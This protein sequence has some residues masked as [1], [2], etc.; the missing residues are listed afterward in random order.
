[1]DGATSAAAVAGQM[2]QGGPGPPPSQATSSHGGPRR[3]RNVLSNWGTYLVAIGV[4]FFLSPFII[5][6]L[7]DTAYGIWVLLGSLVG[8]LGLLDLGVRGAVTRYIAKFHARAQHGEA[9]RVASSALVL[10]TA[11]GM[12]AIAF[13]LGL[14]VLVTQFFEI[15][16]PLVVPARI[17]VI[18]GGV[19]VAVSLASGVFGGV[20]TGM[21]RIDCINGI[22]VATQGFRVLAIVLALKWGFG[23]VALATIQLGTS[24]LSGL[25]SY[26]LSRLLYPELRLLLREYDRKH[27]DMVLSF[28]V[29]AFLLQASGMLILFTDSIV[30]GAF[31]PVSFITF[32]AIAASLTEY[33][34]APISAIT[35]TLTP[36]ASALEAVE[37]GHQVQHLVLTAGRL[38]TLLALPILVTFVVR[39]ESFIGLW[40]GPAYAEPAGKVLWILSL[41]LGFAVAYQVVVVT[42][43]GISKHAGLVPAFLVEAAANVG[44]SILWVNVYG[45]VGV[46]WGTA[47]PRLA[48]CL[49][50][51][52]WYVR[53][54]LRVPIRRFYVETW[55]RP[56]AAIVPFALGSYAIE[57]WWPA[58]NLFEYFAQVGLA[59]PLAALGG[60]M[61]CLAGPEKRKLLPP[62]TLRR[63][64]RG[65]A[66]WTRN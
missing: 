34:R 53:R 35:H 30:I 32:F 22:Q 54:V 46:A 36:W 49:L 33:A 2:T 28:G 7:G 26:W 50:F 5:H 25:A 24:C 61:L 3:V 12:L 64:V 39:G 21:Q 14:A 41:A 63:V 62:G 1:M 15:P 19:N 55:V 59:L 13:S 20:V 38:A 23:L 45:I 47:V 40:M 58:S 16:Q 17:V 57:R 37:K 65:L 66:G 31:L 56:A 60:W 42:M 48:A 10:F 52:P 18:V 11:A 27:L 29:S 44:L 43:M 4:S 8:Y 6:S 51:L 9:T